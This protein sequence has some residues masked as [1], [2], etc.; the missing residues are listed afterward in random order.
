MKTLFEK[1]R[2]S[3]G[4][5]QSLEWIRVRTCSPRGLVF[6]PP[7]IGGNLSQQVSSFRWLIRREYDLVSFNYSGHGS[8]SDRFSLGATM[9]DT[10]HMLC[11]T[12]R[13]TEK[14]QLPLFGIASC[15]S[16]IPMLYATHCLKEPI[17]KLVLINAISSLGPQAVISSFMT[18]YRK[19]FP[20]RKSLRRL[21]ATVGHY[22][23]LLF[24]GIAKGRDYFGVLERRRTRLFRTISEFFTLNPLKELH[25]EKTSVL[26]L[27]ARKDT[28]LEIY[29][30]GA[31]ANYQNDILRV[32]PQ[33]LFHP[34]DGD[35]FLSLPMA[36][37]Q[38]VRSILSF[39]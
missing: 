9:R 22:V 30:H 20:T 37:G 33:T 2:Y 39:L 8:S 19:V 18:Y 38:A 27:Y 12:W 35:H 32:C 13:L 11:R 36:K 25:L 26:C 29:D 10:L 1:G 4:K 5:K 23:D 6:V 16:A 31:R 15:Y 7:L 3:V 24:P 14:E 28:V 17:K 21:K 34:L